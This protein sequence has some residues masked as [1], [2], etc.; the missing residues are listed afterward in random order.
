MRQV[1]CIS[2]ENCHIDVVQPQM[3]RLLLWKH[4]FGS[5]FL[6]ECVTKVH[7]EISVRLRI[8]LCPYR[9]NLWTW[10]LHIKLLLWYWSCCPKRNNLWYSTCR[11]CTCTNLGFYFFGKFTEILH[12]WRC[13]GFY[14]RNDCSAKIIKNL[15]KNLSYNIYRTPS[16]NLNGF[17]DSL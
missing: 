2:D 16:T 5:K 1:C 10:H 4:F 12:R 15:T 17:F 8:L 9:S 11:P 13:V 3:S 14:I 7:F 6:L